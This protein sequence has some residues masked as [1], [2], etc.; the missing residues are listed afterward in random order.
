MWQ[1]RALQPPSRGAQQKSA[2]GQAGGLGRGCPEP[3]NSDLLLC[4]KA[5]R[6]MLSNGAMTSVGWFLLV[7]KDAGDCYLK[8]KK[9]KSQDV[10]SPS[11]IRAWQ[12]Q[13]RILW[14]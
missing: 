14:L 7:L 2:A 4:T 11:S 12:K 9:I 1:L 6:V 13:V 8:K 10:L 5:V 3:L